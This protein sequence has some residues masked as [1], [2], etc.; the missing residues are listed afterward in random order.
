M[1]YALS[2]WFTVTL[3]SLQRSETARSAL[4]IPAVFQPKPEV[5][6]PSLTR[7]LPSKPDQRQLVDGKEELLIEDPVIDLRSEEEI[8]DPVETQPPTYIPIF[9]IGPTASLPTSTTAAQSLEEVKDFETDNAYIEPPQS[10]TFTSTL[11][12]AQS[13]W[14]IM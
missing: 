1:H 7:K 5:P 8:V 4:G 14:T 11:K 9:K 3:M 13:K 10:G 6:L 12:S 2:S